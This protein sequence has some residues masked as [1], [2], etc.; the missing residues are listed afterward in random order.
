MNPPFNLGVMPY[1]SDM[2]YD[3]SLKDRGHMWGLFGS[4]STG[5]H[6]FEIGAEYMDLKFHS[7]AAVTQTDLAAAWNWRFLDNWKSRIGTHVIDTSDVQTDNAWIVFAGLSQ[8]ETGQWEAGLDMYV[9]HYEDYLPAATF[10]QF[11]PKASRTLAEFNG[12]KLSGEG[13]IYYIYADEEIGLGQHSFWSTEGRLS[14]ERGPVNLMLYGWAGQQTFA[15]RNDGFL[16]YNLNESHEG[17]Y[18]A[19]LRLKLDDISQLRIK[20]GIERF[21]DFATRI[22]AN[23]RVVNFYWLI[24]F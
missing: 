9:S 22:S 1:Y 3:A 23:Q 4:L 10:Y 14:L 16:V 17:G 19:E 8:Y 12:F 7:G 21:E 13:S 18:G 15:V 5:N 6:E 20:M 11:V 24:S 2:S